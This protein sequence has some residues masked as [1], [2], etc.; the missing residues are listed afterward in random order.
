MDQPSSAVSPSLQV[1]KR[2]HTSVFGSQDNASPEKRVKRTKTVKAYGAKS[3]ARAT[4]DRSFERLRDDAVATSQCAS[5]MEHSGVES[6][7]AMPSG[8]I[9]EDFANHEP[10]VLFRDS[11]STVADSSSAQQRLVEQALR[12]KKRLSTSAVNAAELDDQQKSSSF[13]WSVSEQTRSANSNGNENL[14]PADGD[15]LAAVDAAKNN[16]AVAGDEAVRLADKIFERAYMETPFNR[17]LSP[18][19]E[20]SQPEDEMPT[21]IHEVSKRSRRA[22][23]GRMREVVHNDIDPLNSEDAA[24]GL[25]KELY[26]PRP[27]RR[28]ATDITEEPIDFSVRPEKAAK[29]KRT[30]TTQA[31]TGS[32]AVEAPLDFAATAQSFRSK[33]LHTSDQ[34]DIPAGDTPADETTGGKVRDGDDLKSTKENPTPVESGRRLTQDVSPEGEQKTEGKIFV[35]PSMPSPKKKPASKSKR[36]HTTIFEDH[37]EFMDSQRSPSLSQQQAKRKS[38]LQDVKNEAIGN[39]KR[40]CRTIVTDEDDEEH[41]LADK[42]DAKSAEEEDSPPKKRGRGRPAKATARPKVK[43]ANKVLEDSEDED[44][45]H[46]E[47]EEP[48]KKRGRGRPSKSGSKSQAKAVPERETDNSFE[49]PEHDESPHKPSGVEV[50]S[51]NQTLKANASTPKTSQT[52]KKMPTPSPEKPDTQP[53]ATSQKAAKPSPTSHSPIKNSSKVPLRVGLSRRRLIPPLLKVMKPPK[54]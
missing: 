39:S 4:D 7:A 14:Q 46:S 34:E 17:Q 15:E 45:D 12:N 43:S 16:Q 50:E 33:L 28:R 8:S 44:H 22:S 49:A 42:V 24:I 9:R 30:K 32:L 53:A 54:R 51:Q 31:S 38:A 48:P 2:R 26:K 41:E 1:N 47:I 52:A 36:S 21:L 35:K 23:K 3:R 29:V 6:L 25:P 10:A 27:S 37:V 19:V 13:P 5:F 40:K 20:I 11:G 18:A